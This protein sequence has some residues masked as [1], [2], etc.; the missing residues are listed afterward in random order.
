MP[1]NV[2]ITDRDGSVPEK[3]LERTE[4]QVSKLDRFQSRATH[5]EVVWSE[6]RHS[7]KVEILVFV[8][9]AE[10]I[11][12]RGEAEHHRPALTEAIERAQR[13]LRQQREKRR[14]HQ[15]PPLSEGTPES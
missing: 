5:A 6:E 11:K 8:D 13:M 7:K 1:L 15:A 2:T 9:D 10:P 3:I 4:A 14:D 12:V